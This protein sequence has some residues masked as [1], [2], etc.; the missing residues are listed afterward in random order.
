MGLLYSEVRKRKEAEVVSEKIKAVGMLSGGLDSTLAAHIMKKMGVVIQ[1]V[2][3]ST[4]FCITDHHRKL[5]RSDEPVQKMQ[6]EALRLGADLEIPL[7][8]I[9]ISTEYWDILLNPKHGYGANMNPCI[10]CRIMMFSKAK[11]YMEEIGAHFVFSGEV[12]GQRPKSQRKPTLS[13]I[14][15]QAG[16]EGYLLRP[17][18]AKLLPETIPEQLGWINRD[19]L[20]GISGRSRSRQLDLVDEFDVG[21]YP[22]PAGGCC[23]LT[24]E[25]Y[26]N[27]LSD[28]LKDNNNQPITPE[29]VILL[30]VGRHFR[31][32]P[33]VKAII[34]RDEEES[35]FLSGFKFGRTLL[36]TENYGGPTTLITGD[37]TKELIS[38]VA[39]ITAR[40][41]QGRDADSVTLKCIS[42]GDSSNI[43]VTPFAKDEKLIKEWRV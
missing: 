19:E 12:M 5:N 28:M 8:I 30:K 10:D 7:E 39:R 41:G 29:D 24:D 33:G 17:L 9:D 43:E 35:R 20:Y 42:N 6:N 38:D 31:P 22:Q 37:L 36:E 40:Y 15:E 11:I 2:N 18:S 3:F 4:G 13:I 26:S 25:S 21:Y 32:A 27:K 16:L 14:A 23:T 1:G 34:A